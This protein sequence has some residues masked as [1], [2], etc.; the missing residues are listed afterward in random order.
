[1]LLVTL[2]MGSRVVSLQERG[3]EESLGSTDHSPKLLRKVLK[4]GG[5]QGSL[6]QV[7]LGQHTSHMFFHLQRHAKLHTW[8]DPSPLWPSVKAPTLLKFIEQLVYASSLFIFTEVL[9]SNILIFIDTE[10]SFNDLS[11]S[12]KVIELARSRANIRT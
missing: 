12:F 10:P 8:R 2:D 6:P 3:I 7:N 5:I 1:M 9:A 11:S 4:K